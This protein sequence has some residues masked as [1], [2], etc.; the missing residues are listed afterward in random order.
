MHIPSIL[1]FTESMILLFCYSLALKK[2]LKYLKYCFLY[3][4]QRSEIHTENMDSDL[5]MDVSTPF[6]PGTTCCACTV[7]KLNSIMPKH[8]IAW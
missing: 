3:I 6:P 2:F 8:F 7:L 1:Y 5:H 4:Q